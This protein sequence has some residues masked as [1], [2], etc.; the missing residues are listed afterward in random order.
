[1]KKELIELVDKR[2]KMNVF[3]PEYESTDKKI[4]ELY[5]KGIKIF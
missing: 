4:K 2:S 1:M 5:A 3:N